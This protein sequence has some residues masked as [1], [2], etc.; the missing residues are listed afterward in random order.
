VSRL[1]DILMGMDD[2]KLRRPG[3][4]GIPRLGESAEP[5]RQWRIAGSLVILVM[6][7]ALAATV[8]LRPHSLARPSASQTPPLFAALVATVPPPVSS[9]A[10]GR[11]R[12]AVLMR[13]GMEAAHSG[14][15]DEAAVAFR[16]AVEVDPTDAEAWSSLGVVLVRAGDEARGVEA[17]RRALRA[18]P[19]HPEAHRNLA[20][21]FDRQGR[22][23]EAARHYRA[24]L[25]T[26]PTGSPDRAPIMARL[27]EMGARRTGE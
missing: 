8:A 10:A 16:K 21:V 7:G 9:A 5:R 13:T 6:M 25:A 26:S 27:E 15:M 23:A 1:A 19:G 11:E 20:V 24:F 17:F 22:G 12:M 18:A 4:G 3:L 2:K 14:K